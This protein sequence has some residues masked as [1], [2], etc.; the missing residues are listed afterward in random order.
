[1][2]SITAAEA[3]AGDIVAAPVVNDQGRTLLPKGARLSAAVLSRLE[4][5][6]VH[7]CASR[8]R[9][10]RPLSRRMLSPRPT[11]TCWPPSITVFQSGRGM[12]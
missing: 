9:T 3:R 2:R 6:G 11:R 7:D 5:W 4:G 1:M 8:A 10:T 12:R